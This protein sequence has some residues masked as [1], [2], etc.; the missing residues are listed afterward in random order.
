MTMDNPTEQADVLGRPVIV[1]LDDADPP[2][3]AD[4]G[5]V[6]LTCANCGA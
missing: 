1:M 5:T 2:A 3:L 6:V 4:P